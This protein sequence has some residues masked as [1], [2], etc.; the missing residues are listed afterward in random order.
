[1]NLIVHDELTYIA[2]QIRPLRQAARRRSVPGDRTR[3]KSVGF[4][5]VWVKAKPGDLAAQQGAEAAAQFQEILD[6]R[7]I[8]VNEPIGA[9]AH[10]QLARAHVLEARTS[11]GTDAA[12]ARAKARAAYQD[13]FGLWKNADPDIPVPKQA[14]SEY[15]RLK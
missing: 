12:A 13:F 2:R 5:R 7:A 6:H 4:V 14:R 1:M 10:L 11:Y 8:V 9:L 15:A 3:Q